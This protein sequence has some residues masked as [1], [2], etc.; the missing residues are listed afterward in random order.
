MYRDLV[1]DPEKIEYNGKEWW[2]QVF[3]H[4]D[5]TV[6]AVHLYDDGGNLIGEFQSRE[7]AMEYMD[8]VK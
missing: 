1:D 8:G 5:G 3:C 7:Q 4:W 6:K 2:V